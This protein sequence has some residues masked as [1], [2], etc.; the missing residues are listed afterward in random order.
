[1]YFTDPDFGLERKGQEGDLA[2]QPVSGLY[3][4]H[5]NDI[6]KA[7]RYG[8]P[9]KNVFLIDGKMSHPKG[10]AFSPGY[11]RLYVSNA[12]PSNSYWKVFDVNSNGLAHKGR[13]FYNATTVGAGASSTEMKGKPGGIKVD[14][15]GNI[16][17]AGP[18][19]V[20]VFDPEAKLLG[21]FKLDREVTGVEFGTDGRMYMTAE[22]ALLRKWLK[23]KPAPK[24]AEAVKVK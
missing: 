8:E 11:S 7:V 23:S 6:A 9:A 12:D 24:P 13:L 3:M 17:A 1:M 2:E 5:A 10:L 4:V 19:G 21:K 14:R 16:Y 15:S 20:F 22:D 18:G